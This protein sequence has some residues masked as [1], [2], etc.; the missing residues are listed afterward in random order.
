MPLYNAGNAYLQVVP[1]FK[2]IEAL[3]KKELAKLGTQVDKS[4]GDSVAQ[5]MGDGAKAGSQKVKEQLDKDG[6]DAAGAFAAKF[7]KRAAQMLK[8]LGGEVS[9]GAKTKDFDEAYNKIIGEVKDLSEKKIGPS[10]TAGQ[11][12]KEMDDLS[13][14]MRELEQDA[15]D[16]ERQF[17]L[18]QAR[19]EAE[20]FFQDLKSNG[21]TSGAEFGRRFSGAMNEELRKGTEG[22]LKALP[23]LEID[24]DSSP[25]EKKI[26]DLRVL[27]ERLHADIELGL[28]DNVASERLRLIMAELEKLNGYEADPSIAIN[29]GIALAKLETVKKLMD[30]IDGDELDVQVDVND[31]KAVGGLSNIAEEAGVTLSRLGYLVSFGASLGTAL[32]PAA[33][34]AAVAISGIGFAAAGAAAGI[35]TLFLAFNGVGDAVKALHNYNQDANKSAKSLSQS[36][37]QIASAMD[38][39]KSAQDSLSSARENA[40]ARAIADQQRIAKAVRDVTRARQDAVIAVRDAT[41]AAKDA[42]RDYTEALAAQ[43]TARDALNDSYKQAVRDMAALDSE[44]K[45]N[46]LDQRQSTLDIKKAKEDLDKFLANPRATADEREQAKIIYQEK[47]LQYQDLQRQAEKL[48]D[49]QAK[50]NKAGVAGSKAVTAAQK[51]LQAANKA[52]ERAARAQRDTQE[53]LTRV[54]QDSAQKIADSQAALVDAQRQ[55]AKD[56]TDSQ[57]QIAAAQRSIAAANRQLAQS[58]TNAGVAGGD[59]LDTLHDKLADLSPAGRKFVYFLDGTMRPAMDRL[60]KAAQEGLFPGLTAGLKDLISGGRLDQVA[61]FVNGVAKAMGDSFVYVVKQLRDPVWKKFFGY[62]GQTAAPVIKGATIVAFNFAKG[63]ANIMNALTGFNG[64]MGKGLIDFSAKFVQWSQKLTQSDGFQKF[65][66]YVRQEG[67]H[68]LG[69]LKQVAYFAARIVIAAAPIGAL[70]V[71]AFEE[72]FK[73]LNM[74]PTKDLMLIIGA[75]VA[76]S[77]AL[78]VLAAGTAIATA[79][80]GTLITLGVAALGAALAVLYNHFKPF[81]SIV[82]GTFRIVGQTIVW[83]WKNVWIPFYVALWHGA[84]WLYKNVIVPVFEGFVKRVIALGKGIASL[85]PIVKPAVSAIGNTFLWLWRN[86]LQP[87]I[88][89]IAAGFVWLWFKVLKP[90]LAYWNAGTA[91]LAKQQSTFWTIVRGIFTVLAATFTFLWKAVIGPVLIALGAALVFLWKYV[92]VPVF[93]AIVIVIK[94]AWAI[95]SVIFNAIVAVIKVVAAIFVWLYKN[96]VHPIF[97]LIGISISIAWALIKVIFGSIQIALKILGLAFKFLYVLFVKPYID[98]AVAAWNWLWGWI[99]KIGAWI[100]DKLSWLGGKIKDL[101]VKWVQPWVDKFAGKIAELYNEHLK[102]WIDKIANLWDKYVVPAWN[103]S[104]AA[105]GKFWD[106]LKNA[107]KAF[108]HWLVVDVLNNGLLAGYNKVAKFF[109][110]TPDDVQIKLPK[111]FAVGGQID[112]PGTGTSD[113]ILIRAS[114][115]EH[116]WTAAEVDALGGHQAMYALRRA[117]AGGYRPPGFAKG[118]AIDDGNSGVL[119]IGSWLKKQAK[120]VGKKAVSLFNSASS[121]FADPVASLQALLQGLLAKAPNGVADAAKVMVGLPKKILT[122]LTDKLKSF[123]GL[124]PSTDAGSGTGAGGWQWQESVLKAAFGDRVTFTSTTGGGHATNSWHYKGRALDSIGPDMMAI[125]NWIMSH[126]GKTSKELIYSPAGRGIKNGQLVDIRSFYGPSVY[127]NH[128]SHVHWAY[129][130]GGYLQPGYSMVYNGTGKPEPVLTNQQWN[131]I[132]SAPR[133]YDGPQEVHHWETAGTTITPE[134]LEANQRRRDALARINRRNH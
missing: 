71:R 133:N 37:N 36:T 93:S 53:T 101:Y 43:K 42:D 4:L 9:I 126:F 58:Y 99:K 72:F 65:M 82:D 108:I 64:G 1:S 102:P 86:V 24:A 112:G 16:L 95:L 18:R 89:G 91:D 59:A 13:K 76:L 132:A 105:L 15:P 92:V 129:D 113:S 67:P 69:L 7:E 48:A 52:V 10:F 118:G 88:Q 68:V 57:R 104:I 35:G 125:F 98:L 39:V 44:V 77:A 62:I 81:K 32:V 130:Q 83:L 94:V 80:V 131:A 2:G 17:N 25:A 12:A 109:H 79:S 100:A 107:P 34:A 54:Q 14:K 27:L 26:A 66:E 90:A 117:I 41:E 11:A 75:I 87:A 128:F 110:V 78:L 60:Q 19:A 119:G 127:S 5:G 121:F 114:K 51:D 6:E 29:S 49:E 55:Q 8:N 21:A 111:G 96:I 33:A 63:I 22:A 85:W 30:S 120:N 84:V 134:W 46:A 23:E 38:A 97:T 61:K 31:G 3:M 40:D 50:S 28:D 106:W 116:M 103:K 115:G 56:Q 123:V 70:V 47:L 20:S 73:I 122:T 45:H 124:G 74:I